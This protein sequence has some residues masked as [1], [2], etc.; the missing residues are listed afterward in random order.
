MELRN[1]GQ[2]VP[3]EPKNFDLL[4]LL[5]RNADR[6]VTRDEIF[7][8]VWPGVFVTDA[9]LSGAIKQIRRALG[10]DG[11]T[12]KFI[13]TVHGRGFRFVAEVAARG[14]KSTAAVAQ[15]LPGEDAGRRPIHGPPAIAVLPF[16]LIGTEDSHNAIAEAVPTELIATLSRLRSIRVIARGSAFRFGPTDIDFNDIHARLGAAYVLSG[17]VELSGGHLS[18]I[19]ELTDARNHRVVWCETFSG[20][21]EEVFAIRQTIASAV[22]NAV[23]HRVA[24]NEA[25]GLLKVPSE[26]LNAWGLYHLGVHHLYR[27]NGADNEKAEHFLRRAAEYDPGF[28]RALAG[29]SYTE[30]EN[31]NLGFGSEKAKHRSQALTLAEK[32]VDLDPYDPF[33]NLVLG[34]AKWIHQEMDE[35][36]SWV[37]RSIELNPNYAFAHYNSGKLNAIICEGGVADR[38]VQSAMGLSP[39]DPHLQSMLSARALAAFVRKDADRA[40]EFADRSIRAPNAHLYVCIIAA[41]ILTSYGQNEKAHFAKRKLDP[42]KAGF[43]EDH[44]WSLFGLR[45]PDRQAAMSASMGQLGL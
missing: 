14:G 5:V 1:H 23:E 12:Q 40:I 35:A 37:D 34:R 24:M 30:L 33:C 21:L 19:A 17:S 20:P 27:F 39:I 15:T 4:L 43:S 3:L 9:S 16:R 28:A 26:N 2:A 45:D 13:K 44:F 25:D 38:H 18:V 10:D 6:V 32:A 22:A 41:A 29:L 8:Q 7:Q 42:L 36:I 31:C 11:S